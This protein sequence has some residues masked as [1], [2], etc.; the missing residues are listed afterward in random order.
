[1]GSNKSKQTET[2]PLEFF[3]SNSKRYLKRKFNNSAKQGIDYN[4]VEVY[5]DKTQ[6]HILAIHYVSAVG[7]VKALQLLLQNGTDVNS[8]T[9][10][11]HSPFHYAV[12][13][14]NYDAYAILIDCG[15][16]IDVKEH[17]SGYTP[18]HYAV[19]NND[20]TSVKLL[21]KLH[22]DPNVKNHYEKTPV[23]ISREQGY[24]SIEK[25][26]MTNIEFTPE[27]LKDIVRSH[28]IISQ[29]LNQLYEKVNDLG[30]RTSR[31]G[32]IYGI[33]SFPGFPD[34]Q[35]RNRIGSFGSMQY[36]SRGSLGTQPS[37]H[38][39]GIGTGEYDGISQRSFHTLTGIY[40]HF[41]INCQK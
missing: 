5:W 17:H 6:E 18:L 39:S 14:Q 12:I 4:V 34:N 33:N 7:S 28:R 11:G 22:A 41:D 40:S 20:F 36:G 21:L 31:Y 38:E 25:L 30:E 3:K 10:R 24:Q 23:D 37:Y 13:H 16:F 35:A 29:S 9:K 15:G 8:L 32:S 26:L 27:Q 1:M 19:E 2:V